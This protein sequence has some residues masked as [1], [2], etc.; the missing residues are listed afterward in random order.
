MRRKKNKRIPAM[1][2]IIILAVC[3]LAS[4]GVNIFFVFWG[5]DSYLQDTEQIYIKSGSPAPGPGRECP[6]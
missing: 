5:F 4:I 3:L 1:A 2:G 6:G